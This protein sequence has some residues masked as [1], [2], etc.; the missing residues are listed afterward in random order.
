M[1]VSIRNRV[2]DQISRSDNGTRLTRYA[3]VAYGDGSTVVLTHPGLD[4]MEGHCLIRNNTEINAESRG[5]VSRY[6]DF[7]G[8]IDV[9]DAGS[10]R[11]P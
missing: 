6:H 3:D 4:V 7:P 8:I 5:D 1:T 2:S 9:L 11:F 10:V